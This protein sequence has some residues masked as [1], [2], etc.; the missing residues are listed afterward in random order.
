MHH[1]AIL[2]ALTL[3]CSLGWSADWL[4]DGGDPKRTAWQRDET[5]FSKESISRM[6]LLWKIQLDNEPRQMVIWQV[7]FNTRR[8]QMRRAAVNRRESI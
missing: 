4:A 8:K 5:I 3:G 6:K 7:I 1:R 2:I